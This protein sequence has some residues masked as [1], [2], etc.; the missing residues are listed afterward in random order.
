VKSS[1]LATIF[2]MSDIPM[3]QLSNEPA[4]KPFLCRLAD[5]SV[6]HGKAALEGA[7]SLQRPPDQRASRTSRISKGIGIPKSQSKITP[8]SA[9]C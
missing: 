4:P 6:G 2:V 7:A 1:T 3:L 8:M 5:D 9:S